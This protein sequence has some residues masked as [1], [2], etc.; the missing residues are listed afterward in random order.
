MTSSQDGPGA[1]RGE[2]ADLTSTIEL[3][4]RYKRG[5]KRSSQP[6]GG[7]VPSPLKRWARGRL[8]GWARSLAETQDLVQDAVIRAFHI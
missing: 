3:L 2:A 5:D 6:A 7:T 4:D 1:D 8:P